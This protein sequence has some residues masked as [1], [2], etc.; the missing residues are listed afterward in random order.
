VENGQVLENARRIAAAGSPM[1]IR[2]PI[3]PGFTADAAN[4]AALGDFIAA[5]LPA[6]QRWD[7]LAYTNLGGPKYSRLGR[8]NALEGVPL[9]A[10]AEMEALHA[11]ALERVPVA[12]WSGATT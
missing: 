11:V 7:L 6:V 5:E 10:R 3:I 1:W 8:A 9:L 2:T 12:Q 4:I